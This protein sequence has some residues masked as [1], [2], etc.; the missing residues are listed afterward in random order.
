MNASEIIRAFGGAVKVAAL[1][2]SSRTAVSNWRSAG[3]PAKHWITLIDAA[4]DA[5]IKGVTRETVSA[6]PA[7]ASEAA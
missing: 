3:I 1:T 5:G 6:R 2:G 4:A 7:P